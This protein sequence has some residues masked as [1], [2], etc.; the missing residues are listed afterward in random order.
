MKGFTEPKGRRQRYPL[1]LSCYGQANKE[2]WKIS[3]RIMKNKI[4]EGCTFMFDSKCWRGIVPAMVI[5]FTRKG[6]V[7]IKGTK[8]LTDYL[9]GSGVHGLFALSSTGEYFSLVNEQK[10]VFVKTVVSQARKRVPIYAGASSN[11][12]KIAISN[13]DKLYQWGVDTAVIIPPSFFTYFRR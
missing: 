11:S 8:R 5:P 9:I 10:E 2:I 3:H 4:K 1:K 12:L 7:D 6:E 13:I